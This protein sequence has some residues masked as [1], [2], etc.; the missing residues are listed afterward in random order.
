MCVNISFSNSGYRSD[1]GSSSSD[2]SSSSDKVAGLLTVIV[3]ALVL[4]V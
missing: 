3:L 2:N 1:N 4:C